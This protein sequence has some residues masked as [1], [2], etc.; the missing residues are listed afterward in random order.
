MLLSIFRIKWWLAFDTWSM[1]AAQHLKSEILVSI[2]ILIDWC[3]SASS[4]WNAGQHKTLYRWILLSIFCIKCWSA[5]ETWSMDATQHL[6][7]KML[8]SIWHLF[9]DA[10]QHLQPEMLV[11]I[12][13]LID[14]CCS[15]SSEFN[16]GQH[17]TLHRWMLPSNFSLKCW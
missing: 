4:A 5:F 9:V 15:A 13:H 1:D 8:V 17:L 7:T 10:A 2:W 12:R 6:Q 16:A 11:N 14:G 3:C